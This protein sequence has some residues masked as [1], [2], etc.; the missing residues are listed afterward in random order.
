M[1]ASMI[2]AAAQKAVPVEWEAAQALS[3]DCAIIASRAV[4]RWIY[5]WSDQGHVRGVDIFRIEDGRIAEKLSYV[6]G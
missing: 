4:Q 5:R 3:R 6:K 2:D 1:Q